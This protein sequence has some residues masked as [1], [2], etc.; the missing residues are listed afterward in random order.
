MGY[1]MGGAVAIM[2][3]G[4]NEDVEA[5]V[6]D[7]A[8]ATTLGVIDYNFR[9]ALRVPSAPVA[10]VAD[11]LLYWRSGYHFN[12]VETLRNIVHIA[13]RPILIIHCRKDS[14]VDPNDAPLLLPVSQEA[15]E[16]CF[17]PDVP[18]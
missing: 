5:L 11:H 17:P 10:W 9:R 14:L 13:P 16:T 4:R 3:C 7:S 12:Q 6:V 18:P 15:Q 1:S 2:A 8:F